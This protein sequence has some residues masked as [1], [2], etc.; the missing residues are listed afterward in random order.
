VG[1]LTEED[2]NTSMDELS[3]KVYGI[4]STTEMLK[5][6]ALKDLLNP[7]KV[8]DND[9]NL[10]EDAIGKKIRA[11]RNIV[12]QKNYKYSFESNNISYY[13]IEQDLLP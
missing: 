4:P 7:R 10:Y 2:L 6:T 9:L 12:H 1:N 3:E 13:W 11:L 8:T 5:G